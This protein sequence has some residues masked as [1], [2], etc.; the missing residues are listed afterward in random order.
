LLENNFDHDSRTF[1][2]AAFNGY[3]YNMKWLLEN[4]FEHDCDTFR[5]AAINGNIENMK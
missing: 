3:L 5:E 2:E 1:A 4:N